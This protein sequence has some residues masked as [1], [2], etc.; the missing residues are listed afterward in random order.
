[1]KIIVDKDTC[2][3]SAACVGACPNVFELGDDRKSH[4]TEKYR[5]KNVFVG[6]VPTDM[7]DCVKKAEATCPVN[8]ISTE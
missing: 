5:G 4:I 2:I 6:K 8:A 7:E 1:M 3:G